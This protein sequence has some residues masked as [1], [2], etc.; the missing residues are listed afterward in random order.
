MRD[1]VL[2]I[3][4]TVGFVLWRRACIHHGPRERLLVPLHTAA[5]GRDVQNS[6]DQLLNLIYNKRLGLSSSRRNKRRL[7]TGPRSY[8][9]R[10]RGRSRSWFTCV[11]GGDN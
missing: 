1:E 8:A 9:W 3:G 5:S 10:V 4:G 2:L 11:T 7:I 6:N